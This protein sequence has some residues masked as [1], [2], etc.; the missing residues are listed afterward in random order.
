MLHVY[1]LKIPKE[2]LCQLCIT[3]ERNA[4]TACGGMDQTISIMAEKNKAKLIEFNP[5]IKIF[6]VLIP[7]NVMLV[8]ANSLAPSPKLA[9]L[10]KRY[11]MRV[12]E[13]RLALIILS[14]KILNYD[15]PSKV[16]FKTFYELQ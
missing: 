5:S 1:G 3:S 13:C 12:V 8:I 15:S 11:N 4:G 16:T 9:T 14:L 6:D 7:D 2:K 10:Y